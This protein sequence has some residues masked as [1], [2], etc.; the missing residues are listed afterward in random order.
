[1]MC[2]HHYSMIQ[3][4]FT[5]LKILCALPIHVFFP[6]PLA[7][8]DLFTVPIAMPFPECHIVGIIQYGTFSDWLLSLS[9]MYKVSFMSFRGLIAH[10]FLALDNSIVWMDYSLFFP[11]GLTLPWKL[12]H[13][14][15][16]QLGHPWPSP[17]SVL[18]CGLSGGIYRDPVV[19][20]NS[21]QSI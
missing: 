19:R 2:I 11:C 14:L 18:P 8:T 3:N 17:V 13:L 6:Q 12:G 4:I 10:F 1:M 5:A 20:T 15:L 9:N 21:S 7:T 16:W